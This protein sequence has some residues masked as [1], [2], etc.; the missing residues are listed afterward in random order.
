MEI[1][2]VETNQVRLS[3]ELVARGHT[4][5]VI[6]SGGRLTP[7]LCETGARHI[8]SVVSLRRPN[9]LLV[10]SS[11]V[12]RLLAT[13]RFDIVH[14]TSAAAN[15]C[16][17]LVQRRPDRRWRVVSSP[18]G[19]QNSDAERRLTTDVRNALLVW[20]A[21]EILVISPA[22]RDA[23]TR[24]H[25]PMSRM[26]DA[27]IV[28]LDDSAFEFVP[29][30]RA[31]A[32]EQLRVPDDVKLVTT[33]G[34]L[35]PRKSHDL[36]VQ[37]AAV[38]RE[39]VTNVSF[40][41]VGGGPE[42]PALRRLADGLG[43]RDHVRFTGPLSDVR[44]VLAATDVYVKPGVVEGF[45]GITV[46]EAMAAGKPVVAFDTRDVRVAVE[47]EVT[48]L[49]A[50]SVAELADHVVALLRDPA[51]AQRIGEAGLALVRAR[52]QMSSIAEDL[53]INYRA[54]LDASV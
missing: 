21:D 36:F 7:M 38:V 35:H 29:R 13:E 1:G 28:G 6:S 17:A 22:I 51:R 15:I 14:V 45:I 4:V 48:G 5:T 53:E 49:I 40:A 47:Q 2:G 27:R 18:M 34:A 39:R 33:I 10:T 3:R 43:L 32:R 11:L 9:S 44:H 12:R 23:L 54:S 16:A 26:R 8:R 41:I 19:L 52:F 25:V 30:M 24:I 50:S 42:E 37:M 31:A 20:R 46:L